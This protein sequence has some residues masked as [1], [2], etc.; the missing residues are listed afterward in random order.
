MT[1]LQNLLDDIA[2]QG[3]LVQETLV[4]DTGHLFE[5]RP[6]KTYDQEL[7]PRRAWEASQKIIADCEELIALLTPTKVKLVTECTANNS[8]VGLGVAAD[9]KI[10]DKIIENGGEATLAQLAR[11]CNT[12][13]HKLGSVMHMLCHRH[14]FVE[15]APD[16]FRNNRHSYELRSGTGAAEMMLVETEEGY[17]A[18]LG[19]LP[20]MKSPERMHEIDPAK[21][22]FAQVFGVDVGVLPWLDTPEGANLGRKFSV[23]VPWLSSITVVATRTD[24][25]WDAYGTTVCD[26]GCG[27]GSVILDVK[28]K[29]PHLN[30][31]C[32]DL[33]P[34]IPVIRETFK[35]YEKSM[36]TGEIDI[37]VHD[38]FTPQETV[39][40]V[41]WLR[42]VVRDYEDEVSARILAQL[43]PA[44]RK[45][46]KA[47]VLVN[48]LI[49]PSLITSPTT[50]DTPASRRLPPAQSGYPTTCHMMSLST[51]VLMGG[52]ERTFRDIVKIGES[53]GL[54]FSK[55]HQFRMFT[56][57]VEFELAPESQRPS[58]L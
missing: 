4:S 10:A 34:M 5:P 41:Y 42:G 58:R 47:K 56:G 28:K 39:A 14:I 6:W 25:P 19:W 38:Y 46:P 29:H 11:A 54:K 32:Q 51:M 53:A 21:G 36:K 57:T 44:L 49:V 9:L 12:D 24:L 26:V 3:R 18:G 17:K 37:Q 23:G 15:V 31:V 55:F 1:L 40:D 8:T 13:E 16:V 50:A 48:E 33:A 20:T 30:I 43:I 45:N 35:G 7:P 2:V 52:K 27:P 22:A